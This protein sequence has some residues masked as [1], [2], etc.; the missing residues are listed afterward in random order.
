MGVALCLLLLFVFNELTGASESLA[1][2]QSLVPSISRR[3]M[4][5]IPVAE[6][7]R[8][9]EVLL[10]RDARSRANVARGL[11]DIENIDYTSV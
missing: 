7:V 3:T 6:D 2:R 10:R 9:V 1:V 4:P 5:I 8:K 11:T